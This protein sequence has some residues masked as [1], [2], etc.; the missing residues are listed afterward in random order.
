MPASTLAFATEVEFFF[1]LGG[2][3]FW[4][5]TGALNET[6]IDLRKACRRHFQAIHLPLSELRTSAG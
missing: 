5:H 3:A 2:K 6:N 4:E 1:C